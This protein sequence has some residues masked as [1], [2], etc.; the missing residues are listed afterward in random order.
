MRFEFLIQKT[1]F[2]Y[3]VVVHDDAS[4]DCT[5]GIVREC[6]K[7][8]PQIFKPVIHSKNQYPKGHNY[9]YLVRYMPRG[10]LLW[11]EGRPFLSQTT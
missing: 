6:A 9:V 2:L 10:T 8:C 3:E 11:R 1:D 4:T 5:S 7:H